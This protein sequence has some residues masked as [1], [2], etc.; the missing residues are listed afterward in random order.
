[1]DVEVWRDTIM[2]ATGEL[3]LRFTGPPQGD[4][5]RSNRR[6]V[7][8]STSRNGDQFASDRFLKLFDFAAPRASIA[9]RSTTT[10]PQQFLFLLNSS[11]M[12]DRARI[13][14]ARLSRI[15]E[16]PVARIQYAYQLLYNR[17]PSP[18]ELELG[19]NFTTNTDP[20]EPGDKLDRWIQYCQAL[21]SSNELMFI[22]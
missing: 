4:I 19:L 5:L 11:F 13:F 6:T 10:V 17:E 20:A 18:Q 14:Q 3:D 16:D 2:Q 9:K 7:Y 12:V 8:A 1:M 21:L 22:R 15:S